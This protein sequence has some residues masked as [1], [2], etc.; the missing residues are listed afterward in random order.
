MKKVALQQ[1]LEHERH[2]S[3][4]S[5]AFYIQSEADKEGFKRRQEDLE[6]SLMQKKTTE[7][8]PMNKDISHNLNGYRRNLDCKLSQIND[9]E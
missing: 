2:Q 6:L 5:R 1:V 4:E 8:S 7:V 3:T 9:D